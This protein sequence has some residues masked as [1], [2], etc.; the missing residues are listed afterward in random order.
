[1][2]LILGTNP[3]SNGSTLITGERNR[4]NK[5]HKIYAEKSWKSVNKLVS[6]IKVNPHLKFKNLLSLAK[7]ERV[8]LAKDYDYED[9]LTEEEEK[10]KKELTE[11]PSRSRG[12]HQT[13]IDVANY[14]ERL[15]ETAEMR[16][17]PI[18]FNNYYAPFRDPQSEATLL[19]LKEAD[20]SNGT[21]IILYTEGILDNEETTLSAALLLTRVTK[22]DDQYFINILGDSITHSKYK[23][24]KVPFQMTRNSPSG[25]LQA[26]LAEGYELGE[27]Q[28]KARMKRT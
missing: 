17:G 24:I 10:L 18:L 4:E 19:E 16:D 7:R 13:M 12:L 26:R 22:E 28:L 3:Q 9:Q 11:S 25:T 1:M 2:T 21:S 23:L 8:K 5:L 15:K 27:V 14:Q 20:I 6:A